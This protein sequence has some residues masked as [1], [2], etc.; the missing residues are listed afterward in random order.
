MA[1]TYDGLDSTTK[2]R[3][4]PALRDNIFESNV[5]LYRLLKRTSM[6]GAKDSGGTKVVEPLEYV[7]STKVGSYI[8]GDSLTAA[9]EEFITAAEFDYKRYHADVYIDGLEE[10]QNRGAA[11]VI[12][13]VAAKMKNASKAMADDMATD[14]FSTGVGDAKGFVGLMAITD[15][16]TTVDAYGGIT[17]SDG[18]TWWKG[19]RQAGTDPATLAQLRT[20]YNT[21]RVSADVPTLIVSDFT[22]Q[23]YYENIFMNATNVIWMST[24]VPK[25]LEGGFQSYTF[26]GTPWVEDSHSPGNTVMFLNE[27]YIHMRQLMDF[28]NKGWQRPVNK[29]ELVTHILWYGALTCSNCRMQGHWVYT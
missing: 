9:E 2:K 26:K 23:E 1:V 11:R 7:K 6:M 12:D 18:N 13:L 21:Q 29:D 15:D 20:Q 19:Y 22:Q 10:L 25:T 5:I 3:F 16:A 17:R 28:T 8:K 27:R 4:I 14:A 24:M